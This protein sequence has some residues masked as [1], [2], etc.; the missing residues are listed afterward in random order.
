[1]ETK[2]YK[3][4]ITGNK[5]HPPFDVKLKVHQ[6]GK[7]IS[8]KKRKIE[9][10]FESIVLTNER[11]ALEDFYGG[12]ENIK[13]EPFTI[14]PKIRTAPGLTTLY[15]GLAGAVNLTEIDLSNFDT[16]E[17]TTM[18]GA[19]AHL[20]KVKTLDLSP[21]DTSNVTDM[22]AMFASCYNLIPQFE[23]FDTHNVTDMRGMFQRAFQGDTLIDL[24]LRCFDVSKVT[25]MSIMFQVCKK[26]RSVDIT[27]WDTSKVRDFHHMFDRCS[28]LEEIKGVIVMSSATDYGGMFIDCPSLK[29]K[30]KIRKPPA[31]FLKKDPNSTKYGYEVAGLKLGQ[32]EIVE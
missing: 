15:R 27:G 32:F 14:V 3:V 1:M 12:F 6:D 25:D 17:V 19:F 7:L 28:S 8:S 2:K 10:D 13:K 24:D 23:N 26:L 22:G 5:T 21:L 11:H 4:D 31:G 29:T 16:S 30:V 20:E 18:W 9:A